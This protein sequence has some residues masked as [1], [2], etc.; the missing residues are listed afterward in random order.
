MILVFLAAVV[1]FLLSSVSG[2]G[3]GLLLLPLLAARLHGPAAPAALTIGTT[4]SSGTRLAV[5]RRSVRWSLSRWFVPPA[6][7]G[8]LLGSYLLRRLD[9][10]WLE[11]AIGVFLVS[12]VVA[13]VRRQ[14]PVVASTP[15]G[16]AMIMLLGAVAGFVSG[17]TGAVGVLFNKV[18]FD[19]GLRR[20]EVVATRAANEILL[21]LLKLGAYAA[22]GLMSR[23]VLWHGAL[24]G[25]GAVLATVAT[26]RVLRLLPEVTFRRVGYA[27]MIV[28]GVFMLGSAVTRLRAQ[29]EVAM[30]LGGRLDLEI[31]WN[32]GLVIETPLAWEELTPAQQA[33]VETITAGRPIVKLE[34]VR[35]IGARSYEVYVD[36]GGTIVSLDFT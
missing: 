27:A 20:D 30:W 35:R 6:V 25:T 9:P 23:N 10:V 36:D 4:I 18:Y 3:A 28:S 15:P 33:R 32:G 17:L 7:P 19:Y 22:L 16:P 5:F 8:V 2:G 29:P 26:K 1:A 13:L 11:L 14:E 21:H 34:V 24:V 31:E 12:N